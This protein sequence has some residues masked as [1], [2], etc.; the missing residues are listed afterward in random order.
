MAHDM[1]VE[2]SA[3][4]TAVSVEATGFRDQLTTIGQVLLNRWN[5]PFYDALAR[6]DMQGFL[7]QL[8]IFAAIAGGLL[9]LNVSQTWLNQVMRLK[10]REALTLDL[11]QE[12]MRPARAFRLANAGAIGVNPDQRMQ[13]DAGHL[14]DLSTDLGVGL[15]QSLILLAS[16]VSVLWGLSSGFVFHFGGKS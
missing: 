9:M 8:L 5:Q 4:P 14:S 6:R 15:M 12:W 3:Q 7:R 11:I 1:D 16:F 13:Q 10:L 2:A